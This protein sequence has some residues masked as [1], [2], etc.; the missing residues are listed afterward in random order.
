[1]LGIKNGRQPQLDNALNTDRLECAGLA[2][3]TLG[4]LTIPFDRFGEIPSGCGVEPNDP[5]LCAETGHLSSLSTL[6]S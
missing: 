1:M 3:A 2:Y 5:D 6:T 4:G